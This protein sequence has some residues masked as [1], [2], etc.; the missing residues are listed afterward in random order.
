MYS[1]RKELLGV[2]GLSIDVA[3][4][5][6]LD[7]HSRVYSLYGALIEEGYLLP[8]ILPAAIC[9]SRAQREPTLEN[10]KKG[11]PLLHTYNKI[12][13]VMEEQPAIREAIMRGLRS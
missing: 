4:G 3:L 9:Q 6:E 7:H 1:L 12:A 2:P 13:E 8:W 11:N 5:D 10:F